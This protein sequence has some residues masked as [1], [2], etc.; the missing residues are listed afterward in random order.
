MQRLHIAAATLTHTMITKFTYNSSNIHT[1]RQQYF[2]GVITTLRTMT[3]AF[4]NSNSICP[5]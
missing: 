2:K 1:Q 5:Q 4:T 3:T